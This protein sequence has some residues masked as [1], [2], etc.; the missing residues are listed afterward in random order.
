ME[1]SDTTNTKLN[2]KVYQNDHISFKLGE[3][4]GG[5]GNGKVY[6]VS[7]IEGEQ[8]LKD[9]WSEIDIEHLV[10]KFFS[11]DNKRDKKLREERYRRFRRE[12]STLKEIGDS[13]HGIIPMIDSYCCEKCPK[14]DD[15]AWYIMPRAQSKRIKRKE[16]LENILNDMLQLAETIKL[17]HEHNIVHRDIKPDNIL[18]YNNRICLCDFGLVYIESEP[19]TQLGEK[20]G[21]LKILPPEMDGIWEQIRGCDYKSSDVYLF[22]KV[23]WMYIKGDRY[24]FRGEYRRGDVQIYLKKSELEIKTLEPIHKMLEGG[25][26]TNYTD[27]ISIEDCI[28]LLKKQLAVC[29]GTM[30][31]EQLQEYIYEENM[32]HFK[33]TETP[34]MV[35]YTEENTIKKFMDQS[36]TGY[37]LVIS[38]G[39]GSIEIEPLD[40]INYSENIFEI[41]YSLTSKDIRRL[42]LCVNRIQIEDNKARITTKDFEWHMNEYADIHS[43]N[44]L[45]YRKEKGFLLR[46]LYQ[47]LVKARSA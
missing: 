31:R 35:S 25:T 40:I 39:N 32:L 18:I 8:W 42:V 15:E 29:N 13:I 14:S 30:D 33:N 6:N 46:G 45:S 17:I 47:I 37:C 38:D 21:P 22:V 44:E 24:G 7:I 19:L 2:N 20:I 16:K 28:S 41:S 4:I 26:K 36:V 5:G 12:I 3:E 9:N 23:V 11:V 34:N 1:Y 10:V 27:R 43:L